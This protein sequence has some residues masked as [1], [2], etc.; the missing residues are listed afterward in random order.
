[1]TKGEIPGIFVRGNHEVRG[2]EKVED[3]GRKIGLTNMYYQVRR[4][5]N[6]FTIFDTAESESG[7]QWEHD[8]FYDMIP[9]FAEQVE[10]F[11]GMPAPDTSVNNIVL[12][13]DPEFTPSHDKPHADLAKRFKD[14]A[15]TFN[16]DFS[17]SGHTHYF[18]VN[19]PDPNNFNFYRIEDGGRNG[20]HKTKTL[21]DVWLFR[22]MKPETVH[23]I[24]SNIVLKKNPQWYR[25]SLITVGNS[26]VI[27]ESVTDSGKNIA[28][29]KIFALH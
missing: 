25:L 1:L 12:M 16:I 5:N 20:G 21:A 11:E 6:L 22:S 7:D 4:G 10:W 19:E 26:Q 15:N 28:D 2:N 3:L 24:L 18:R 13:H 29:E 17:V 8:G 23:V 9:Y 27:V 14:K